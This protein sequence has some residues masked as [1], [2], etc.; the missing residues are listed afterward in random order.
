MNKKP[1]IQAKDKENIVSNIFHELEYFS[2]MDND[3][4]LSACNALAISLSYIYY[5]LYQ[6]ADSEKT[7]KKASFAQDVLFYINENYDKNITLKDLSE[8]FHISSD[9]I[10][11]KFREV[12]QISP[13]NY[14]IDRRISEAKWMLI[15]TKDS[16]TSISLKVGYE[17]TTHF[18][19]LFLKRV[20]Y[21][22][23]VYRE[24][25]GMDLSNVYK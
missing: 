23:L 9:H 8:H 1:Y 4:S 18:S 25:F 24:K 7:I 10:S 13:I 19:N 5:S 6:N 2:T 15:N 16:L 21:P 20:G 17:N 3:Y 11:H 22:P 12:Y 14:V